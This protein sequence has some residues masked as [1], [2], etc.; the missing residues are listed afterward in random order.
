VVAYPSGFAHPP[1]VYR[2]ALTDVPGVV[3]ANNFMALFNPASSVLAHRMV[4]LVASTYALGNSVTGTSLIFRR[5]TA[6]S[7]GTLVA[8]NTV[9][10]F[11]TAD[12][13]PVTEVRTGNPTVT[14][15]GLA[16][17]GIPP[18]VTPG[19]AN[20]GTGTDV[21]PEVTD[22]VMLPGQGIVFATA[23]GNAN[24]SWNISYAWSEVE[25]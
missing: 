18:A 20:G 21:G 16:L 4:S 23:A 1:R 25:L 10:R 8:A 22:F 19:V 6:Q 17:R 7:G 11:N 3:L 14:A 15:L 13:D 24:Q 9:A 2:F 12:P 5:S